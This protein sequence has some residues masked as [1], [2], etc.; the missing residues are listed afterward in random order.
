MKDDPVREKSYAFAPDVIDLY[1]GLIARREFVLSKQVLRS[2]TSIGANVEEALAGQSRRD[3]IAK[4]AIASKEARECHYWL[5]L[6]R[7]SGMLPPDVVHPLLEANESLVRMLTSIV[8]T[9]QR[10]AEP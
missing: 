4:M 6:L 7:D 10:A 9:S 8:K 1:R 5:R 3:F 2:G